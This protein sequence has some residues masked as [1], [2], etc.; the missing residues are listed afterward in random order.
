VSTGRDGV[1]EA[2]RRL[3]DRTYVVQHK[4][5]GYNE[6]LVLTVWII[7]SDGKRLLPWATIEGTEPRHMSRDT[8][9]ARGERPRLPL[10]VSMNFENGMAYVLV[11]RGKVARTIRHG[12]SVNLDVDAEGRL[13]GIE[14]LKP[15]VPAEPIADSSDAYLG[16]IKNAVNRVAKMREAAAA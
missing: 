4:Q 14:L 2:V 11:R 7:S 12:E 8:D 13:I 15:D 10:E 16:D 1:I 3:E 5:T 6:V 9:R